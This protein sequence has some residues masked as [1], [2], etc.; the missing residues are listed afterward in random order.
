MPRAFTLSL[1]IALMGGCASHADRNPDGVW[2]NQSA[3]DA[4][5]KDHGLRQALMANGPNLEWQINSKTGQ[6]SY[7]SG[8]ERDE[9]KIARVAD[10]KLRIE[11]YGDYVANLKIDDGELIQAASESTPEQYFIKALTPAPADAPQGSSFESALYSA[12]MGG[13]WIIVS[14]DGLGSRVQFLPNGIVQGL[15]DNDRYAL[16]LDGDCASMS[17][18]YDSLWLKKAKEST[19]WIFVREGR[20]LEI[21]QALN[22]AQPGEIPQFLPGP[23]RWLL[24]K[25]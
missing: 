24:E 20:K 14:G 21:F 6:A 11:F 10:G 23:R 13:K 7:S 16:C 17:G 4:A 15:G 2:I 12:Y 5:V 8:F 22:T 1:L 3:I 9:G 19:L 25:Q 18:K